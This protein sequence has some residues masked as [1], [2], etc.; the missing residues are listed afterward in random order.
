MK[1]EREMTFSLL[2]KERVTQMGETE[3]K[4]MR[5]RNTAITL[6]GSAQKVMEPQSKMT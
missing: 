5:Y 1:R 6:G 3:K 2:T 4:R